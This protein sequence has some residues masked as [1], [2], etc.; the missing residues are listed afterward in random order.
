MDERFQN[1]QLTADRSNFWKVVDRTRPSKVHLFSETELR[2]CQDYFLKVQSDPSVPANEL[3]VAAEQLTLIRGEIDR[4]YGDAKYRR[5]QHL[6]RWAITLATVSTITAIALAIA[7]FLRKP[8]AHESSPGD[9][10]TSTIVTASLVT[11]TPMPT[12]EPTPLPSPT[13]DVTLAPVYAIEAPTST[14]TATA[15]ARPRT[16]HRSRRQSKKKVEARGPIEGLFRS[17]FPPR[18]TQ[19]PS[20]GRRR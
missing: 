17:L 2:D 16:K 4:R 1:Q 8:A 7:Q 10:G 5:A 19:T 6:G 18:P 14:P 11:E 3:I 20:R 15:K 12:P 9:F 13:P